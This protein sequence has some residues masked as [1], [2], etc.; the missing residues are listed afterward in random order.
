MKL[1]WLTLIAYG[2]FTSQFVYAADDADETRYNLGDTEI[3]RNTENR[4][5]P[6]VIFLIDTS[7]SMAYRAASNARPS[8]SEQTRL[9]I[10]KNAAKN[11]IQKL[12]TSLPIN[13]SVMRFDERSAAG[14]NPKGGF[15]LQPFT[16]TD[17]A[18]NKNLL[19]TQIDT[20]TLETIG[21]GTPITESMVEAWRYI[22][23]K[24]AV[25]GAPVV[26]PNVCVKYE[27]SSWNKYCVEYAPGQLDAI[28]TTTSGSVSYYKRNPGPNR[29]GSHADSLKKNGSYYDYISPVEATCQKNHIVLFTDGDASVD[30]DENE[31]IK[32]L[33]KGMSMPSGYSTNCSGDGGCVVQFS[34]WLQNTD[35]F[36]DAD[37]TGQTGS[38]I[39]QVINVHTVGGFGA[40][41]STG[42]KMLND[43][44]KY[45][46][47]Q[48]SDH[49]NADGSS[50]HYYSA[51][52]EDALTKALLEVFG[53]IASTAGNFA[54]PA[55]AVNSFNSLEHRDDLYYSVFQ[56]SESPGW[57][58]NIKRYRMNSAGDILD[59]NGNP[60]VNPD[61]GF[62][63]DSAKSFWSAEVDG[64]IVTK[65]GIA[66]RLGGE[67][68]VYTNVVLNNKTI[69]HSDNRIQE[70][71]DAITK[72][73]LDDF[74]PMGTT[75]SDTDRTNALK[76]G[77]GLDPASGLPRK[78]L[79]DPL[80]GT[81]LLV[82]YREGTAIKDVL[83]A[84]TNSG[85][86]HAFDPQKDNAQELWAFMPKEMLPNLPVYE[87]GLSRLVKTYGIDGPMSVYHKD[88]NK[89]RIIDSRETAYLTAGM[90]RGGSH[91]YLLDISSRNNPTL[92]A[93]ISAGNAGFEE[94][95]QTW[96]RMMSAN[97]HWNGKKIPVF[98]FGGG[99]DP[100]EDTKTTRGN[101]ATK[102]N[103]VYMVTADS[104]VTG[105][106]FDLLWKAT[107]RTGN[108]KGITNTDMKSGFSGDLSLVDNDGD[109]T[110][111]LVYGADVGGRIWRFDI[112]KDNTG[113]NSFA[114]GGMLADFNNDTVAGNIRFYTQ[115]DI[116]YTEYG[117]IEIEDANNPGTFILQTLGRY[118]I[119][120]GSGF[121]AGP[122]STTVNDKI[123]V[124]NDYDTEK[125]PVAGYNTLAISDLADYKSFATATPAKRTNGF[126]YDLP[127]NGE[128]V[129]STTMTVND[130]IYVP[131]FRPSDA[132]IEF[133]CEP[134]TGQAR[135]IVLKPASDP[136]TTGRIVLTKDL[137]QGGIV[138]KPVL[139]FPPTDP[140][141]PG[142]VKPIIAIGT[143]TTEPEGDFNAFQKT[144]WRQN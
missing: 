46:H 91:Y 28:A 120:I 59:A 19:Q 24:R 58:G 94:L 108:L 45:G 6:N 93:Q 18:S 87:S 124:I 81:P 115:P 44:A 1:Y 133:G 142:P 134:D 41:T 88:T 50:K 102:G 20:M 7:G 86:I 109:G 96:S 23:G 104:S 68:K 85:Y 64:G 36:K 131:T 31:T 90:R 92:E 53:G 138:P 129:L 43:M 144:Y 47:P 70:T 84:G 130:V 82:T 40:I 52:D 66:N 77:R 114:T 118:Q 4:I 116:S 3:Y 69:I 33:I 98:F 89:D 55:V 38:E 110:V 12:D 117:K 27:G 80:H 57:S 11:T 121:R 83:Y 72:L 79:A 21:G 123:F 30:E 10:V 51:S 140:D 132:N 119:V 75:M 113:A 35:H 16:A 15:V 32:D 65:G 56:P 42:K 67:R 61:T 26:A 97:V 8:G 106:P 5:N 54:A 136:Y 29:I 34:Y 48:N 9:D 73:L 103:A 60:A 76:W 74:M 71:N 127:A 105:K 137:K 141:N 126:Y 49:L 111:D 63:K 100:V 143:E 22:A 135:L 95:G 101:T 2:L 122:L 125:A 25:N 139:I 13:I 99:Y 128:K 78:T 14:S 39:K 62:F 107:G 37:I 112:N 17:S